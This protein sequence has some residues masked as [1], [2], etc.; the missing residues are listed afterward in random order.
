MPAKRQV[1]ACQECGAE[2]A[3]WFGRC[4]ECSAWNTAVV[5]ERGDSSRSAAR[6]RWAAA[7]SP[8]GDA[9][10][11]PLAD[12]DLAHTT[13]IPTGHG[14]LDL[15]LGGGIVP[16]S[17]ILVGGEPGIGKSTLLLQALM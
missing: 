16:G 4:P 8:R 17:L 6:G 5:E 3:K 15:V 11:R 2:S 10:L 14:E 12:V 9:D 7:A 1:F 13:R